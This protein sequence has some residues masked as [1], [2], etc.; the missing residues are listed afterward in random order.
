MNG[1]RQRMLVSM[2]KRFGRTEMAMVLV[3]AGVLVSGC[4]STTELSSTWNDGTIAIDGNASE[5]KAGLTSLKDTK[6]FLGVQNDQDYLYLCLTSPD[7]QFRRQLIGAGLSVWFENKDGTRSGVLFPIGM[8]RQGGQPPADEEGDHDPGDREHMFQQAL[9]DLEVLGP[10]KDDRNL[11]STV[12]VP[13]IGVKIGGSQST[14]VYELK[15]PLKK[16]G[17][18]PYAVDASPGSTV[19][20]AIQRGKFGSEGGGGESR[21]GMR[22]G[23][24]RRRGGGGGMP[25]G[26]MGGNRE[27]EGGHP[28]RGNRAEPLDVSVKVHLAAPSSNLSHPE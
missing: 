16:T 3:L 13:G 10:G 6:V 24:G 17:E 14:T 5:W 19:M 15:M 11:F 12:Q 9:Q 1:R 7:Q 8:M 25:G 21:E 27:E 2:A 26:G 28:F 4:G 18:H 23:G 22:G 20:I